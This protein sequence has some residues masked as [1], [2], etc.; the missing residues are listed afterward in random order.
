MLR[1]KLITAGGDLVEA[2]SHIRELEMNLLDDKMT[3][4]QS[5]ETL[6][7]SSISFFVFSCLLPVQ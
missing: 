5:A 4:K 2:K 3:L 7:A 1:E 6:L